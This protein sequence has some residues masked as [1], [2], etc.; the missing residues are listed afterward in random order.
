MMEIAW[1]CMRGWQAVIRLSEEER[2]ELTRWSSS[3]TLPAGDVFKAR[4]ILALAD[5]H[6]YRRIEDELNTSRPRIARWKARFKKERIAGLRRDIWEADRAR[7]Q[8]PC[9]P[10]Y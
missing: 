6:S 7:P 1:A 5:G 2:E 9:R 10:G 8:P 3:R 4:L